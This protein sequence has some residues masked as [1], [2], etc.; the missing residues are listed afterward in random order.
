MTTLATGL[1]L[2]CL[3]QSGCYSERPAMK[4]YIQM[5]PPAALLTRCEAPPEREIKTNRDI[6]Y[7]LTETQSAFSECA[8]K[9]DALRSYYDGN[10]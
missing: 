4:E 8:A 3:S 7:L 5:K 2:L 10:N 9:I 6:V 1:T